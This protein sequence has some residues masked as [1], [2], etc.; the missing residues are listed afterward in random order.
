MTCE[1]IIKKLHQPSIDQE[2]KLQ[3]LSI[4]NNTLVKECVTELTE[5]KN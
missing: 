3:F 5:D 2:H 1:E 4:K